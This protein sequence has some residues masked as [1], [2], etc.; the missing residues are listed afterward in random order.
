MI[1]RKGKAFPHCAAAKPLLR[2]LS[3][4]SGKGKLT[5]LIPHMEPA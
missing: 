1:G 3:H 5:H 2:M 4:F